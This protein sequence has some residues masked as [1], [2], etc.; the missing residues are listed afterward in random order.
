[1]WAN[2]EI[3]INMTKNT[4]RKGLALGAASALLISGFTA[5]PASSAGLADT[6]F[7]SL[8]PSTGTEY[9][10]LA[11]T[12]STFSLTSNEATTTSTGNLK[13]LVNDAAASI[14]PKGTTTGGGVDA[15]AD[16][17]TD[18]TTVD[19]ERDLIGL[20]VDGIANGSYQMWASAAV[21]LEKN[22]NTAQK[23]VLAAETLVDVV[24]RDDF[25]VFKSQIAIVAA[26]A[27]VEILGTPTLNFV[28]GG[29]AAVLTQAI[30]D[31]LRIDVAAKADDTLNFATANIPDGTYT[32]F[33]KDDFVT[34]KTGTADLDEVGTN[35]AA[36]ALLEVTILTDVATVKSDVD[37]A[38]AA[39]DAEFG[40]VNGATT[41]YLVSSIGNSVRATDSSF[42][43]DSGSTDPAT[44]EV[45]VLQKDASVTART[46]TVTAWMD[47]N[48]NS[49][50]DSTEYASPA[51]TVS[52]LAAADVT[53]VTSVDYPTGGAA[54]V[55]GSVV[56]TPNLNGNQLA[57]GDVQI[58]FTR[59]GST[60]TVYAN[61]TQ[62]ATTRAWSATQSL[63]TGNWI[64]MPH[65]AQ[66]QSISGG[67]VYTVSPSIGFSL[68]DVVITAE[69][70][71]DSGTT[72]DQ[73]AAA[74]ATTATVSTFQTALTPGPQAAAAGFVRV[75]SKVVAGSA[76]A[77]LEAVGSATFVTT[78]I[79][80]LSIG[81]LVTT[82]GFG[83]N[84]TLNMTRASVSS[85][86]TANSF[87]VTDAA[88]TATADTS[89]GV[90]TFVSFKEA[91][92]GNYSAT[93]K[94]NAT[95][96]GNISSSV[97]VASTSDDT[98]LA[99]TATVN[100]QGVSIDTDGTTTIVSVRKGE[101]SV[102]LTATVVDADDVAV[103][104]NRPV[105]VTLGAS[106]S[107][108]LQTGT[109]TVNGTAYSS[110]VTLLTDATGKVTFTIGENDGAVGSQVEVNVAPEGLTGVKTAELDLI[111]SDT[112]YSVLD[113]NDNAGVIATGYNSI[114]VGGSYVYALR[115]L[116]QWKNTPA[117]GTY[118]IKS[119]TTGRTVSTGYVTLVSG[120]GSLTV[121]DSTIGATTS[122]ATALILE[123]LG[124]TG[125][126]A[127]TDTLNDGAVGGG[128]TLTY[129]TSVVKTTQVDAVLLDTEGSTA[130]GSG[131]ADLSATA[132]TVATVAQDR[133]ITNNVRP[134]YGDGST[135]DVTGRVAATITNVTRAGASVTISGPSNILFS[136]GAVDALGSL[137]FRADAAGEFAVELFSNVSQA[138][139]V[140]T[141]TSGGVS[142][143]VKVSFTGP[144]A[145]FG[146]KIA[147]DA[148]A[149][150]MPGTSFKV[151]ATLTDK[152]GNAVAS[153]TS[154]SA[155]VGRML[156]TYTGPGITIATMPTQTDSKGQVSFTILLGTND[157]GT[158]V[159][160][161]S[162]DQGDD[163][164]F[165]GAA[166]GD[167][168]VTATASITVGAVAS[169]EK[170][171]VGT[172]KGY[173]ALY[174]KGYK[175]QK[176][177][178]IVA[179]KWI[180]VDS[181]AS[182]FERVVRYTG[183]GYSITTK[184]YIDGVQIGDAFTTMTK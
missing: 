137:T 20:D 153:T 131:T 62:G 19:Y 84:A 146:T 3:R 78:S 56:L 99:S 150:V 47:A 129:N 132:A 88:L 96:V 133:R 174:A 120:A 53:A 182:D 31:N 6:S 149:S 118:R 101:T 12:G 46:A 169:A 165:D 4:T 110:A 180:K 119:E 72:A 134:G 139:T 48:G 100:V 7:V 175:G 43:V 38:A 44:N 87:V 16:G 159:V 63:E 45:L 145:S 29:E 176:M 151:T 41:L 24:V 143:T 136:D 71:V 14:L 82:S 15:L 113:I 22:G 60:A 126:W 23:T 68:D 148:P 49:L 8:A 83:T 34:D 128:G 65:I 123:K 112:I 13:W 181:L 67:D 91:V 156:V 130:Y 54:N 152:N 138:N 144:G 108:A 141:V 40:L 28:Q 161:V 74:V 184:I 179:G 81:D 162:Y 157:S 155:T 21:V 166:A 59:P 64:G 70:A 168:D 171:N 127:T 33:F 93:S 98:T 147:I 122:I 76:T 50:I 125:V 85:V 164:D 58:G 89:G 124:T 177:T 11:K 57:A 61:A 121:T 116:D 79:H 106:E 77:V 102:E 35:A 17:T 2:Q 90:V 172:F 66:I 42:V 158:G 52:W 73:A 178:A 170:V 154:T 104:A 75:V 109:Y 117:D 103:T 69:T 135:A 107:N 37:L 32:G 80:G 94:V 97:T 115:V 51:R 27:L 55:T 92:A 30:A 25:A 183:A 5:L 105:V 173:V 114:T 142:K 1:L 111:W 167:L 95:A 9:N 163:A 26:D 160:S 86:P 39:S 18:L 10:V 140:I 36:G